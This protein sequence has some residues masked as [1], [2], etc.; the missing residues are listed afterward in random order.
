M[1]ALAMA[2]I[3]LLALLGRASANDE[4]WD[5]CKAENPERSIA[6]CT[7]IISEAKEPPRVLAIAYNNRGV[8]YKAKRELL[9]A[10]ADYTEALRLNP[11]YAR[12]YYNRARAHEDTGALA[13]ALEDYDAA[14]Q[15]DPN[16]VKALASRAF[17]LAEHDQIDEAVDDFDRALKSDKDF[18]L[19]PD[20][21]LS[22]KILEKYPLNDTATNDDRRMAVLR[23]AI[24][25]NPG[26]AD[27]YNA[28]AEVQMGRG[29]FAE[30]I[31]DLNEAIKLTPTSAF[32]YAT[33]TLYYSNRCRAYVETGDLQQATKDCD[34][35]VRLGSSSG[36][37]YG[38]GPSNG[39]PYASRGLLNLRKSRFAEAEQDLSRA[40][41]LVPSSVENYRLRGETYEKLGQR[42]EAIADYKTAVSMTP[43]AGVKRDQSAKAEAAAA[44]NRL[45]APGAPEQVP[46]AP[47]QDAP[48]SAGK[49]TDSET[50]A[51]NGTS[52]AG[53]KRGETFRD[54]SDCPEMIVVPG[55]QFTMGSPPGEAKA[56]DGEGPQHKVTIPRSFAVGRF[57][58]TQ[59]EFDA[60]V[61]ATEYDVG[62]HCFI[63]TGREWKNQTGSFHAPGFEQTTRHPAACLNWHDAKAYVAWLVQTTGRPYRLLTEAE[64]EYAARAGSAESYSFG[65]N[66]DAL[67][68]FANVADRTAKGKY[69]R[70]TTI[71]NCSDGYVNTGSCAGGPGSDSPKSCAP[72]AASGGRRRCATA[73]MDSASP[74]RCCPEES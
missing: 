14:L 72:P 70:W 26:R 31:A 46:A 11:G 47:V 48:A 7:R 53:R 20:P 1:R 63:W 40:I 43:R 74:E 41:Q 54:C 24:G 12:A 39:G 33:N 27:L 49:R 6:G 35:A 4:D 45:E 50:P 36:P 51:S 17:L 69:S 8:A 22:N 10:F 55:G 9:R 32:S 23:A 5:D 44:L 38:L 73:T 15:I 18:N 25:L 64:W 29:A 52:D 19:A 61:K 21:D 59:G 56:E 60:F 2:A 65:N 68:G 62:E 3:A 28:R 42:A 71:A 30:A 13:R 37:S 57:E 58:V 34:E 66:P 67:C 16:Y